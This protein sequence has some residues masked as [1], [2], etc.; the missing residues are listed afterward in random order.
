MAITFSAMNRVFE[1]ESKYKIEEKLEHSFNQLSGFDDKNQ[2]IKESQAASYGQAAKVF[3]VALKVYV[4][5]CNLPDFESATNLLPML[6]AAVDTLMMRNIR[7]DYPNEKIK[8]KTIEGVS[9]SE[10]VALRKLVAKNIEDEFD[11][12]II[13]VQY[14]DI[15]WYRL[16]R[17]AYHKLPR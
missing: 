5:Y 17:R 1:A 4:Y 2:K 9:K 11:N 15:M 3:N 14:D 8:A 13:P 12:Q 16:N 7:K 6:H 10:Y